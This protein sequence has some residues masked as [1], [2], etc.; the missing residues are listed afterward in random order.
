MRTSFIWGQRHFMFLPLSHNCSK[1]IF[2]QVKNDSSIRTIR[3]FVIWHF[4]GFRIC[5]IRQDTIVSNVRHQFRAWVRHL[6]W[7]QSD[8]P[9][10]RI[11]KL[12]IYGIWIPY[13][14]IHWF[15]IGI[16]ISAVNYRRDV[17]VNKN[18]QRTALLFSPPFHISSPLFLVVINWSEFFLDLFFSQSFLPNMVLLSILQHSLATSD[19][20]FTIAFYLQKICRCQ[21]FHR[22]LPRWALVATCVAQL[23]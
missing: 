14:G 11:L 22:F 4:L 21:S 18:T 6:F 1:R 15:I 20:T 9:I 16:N 13:T 2:L 7:Q 3:L 8:W 10:H 19:W 17:I 5:Q 12:V 23:W